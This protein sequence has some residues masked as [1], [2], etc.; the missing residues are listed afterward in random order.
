MLPYPRRRAKNVRTYPCMLKQ[1][2]E[3][4]TQRNDAKRHANT[5]LSEPL[6]K[7]KQPCLITETDCNRSMLQLSNVKAHIKAKRPNVERLD[8]FDCRPEFQRFHV[9]E[10]LADH[11]QA[12]H[13]PALKQT[14][15]TKQR[16]KFSKRPLSPTQPPFVSLSDD[17]SDVFPLPPTGRFPIPP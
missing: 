5:H 7:E 3:W 17:D 11:I 13:L 1:C 2:D 9:T 6:R 10:A 15:Q 14:R 8:C 12:E 16:R 4:F